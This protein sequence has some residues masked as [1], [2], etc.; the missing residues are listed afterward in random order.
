[1]KPTLVDLI[2]ISKGFDGQLVLD[3][4]NL[5]IH[6]NGFLTLL[7]PSGCGKTTTGRCIINLYKVSDG[8]IY[9]NGEL[10]N[11]KKTKLKIMIF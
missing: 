5:S 9:F 11:S 2:H 6:E 8:E 1:M 3:D 10:I 7:G 4:L